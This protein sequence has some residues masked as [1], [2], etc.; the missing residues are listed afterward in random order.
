MFEAITNR[1]KFLEMGVNARNYYINKA[2]P[3]HMAQG[4]I[5]A[6]NYALAHK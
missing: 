5:D 3:I 2:T 4:F 1:S 6:I